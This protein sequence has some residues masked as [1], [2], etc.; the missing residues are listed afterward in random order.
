MDGRSALRK[1]T[2]YTGQHNTEKRAH[3]SMPRAGF[4]PTIPAFEWLK[5]VRVLDRAAIGTE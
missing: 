5:T 3:M 1:A 2:T 4:E